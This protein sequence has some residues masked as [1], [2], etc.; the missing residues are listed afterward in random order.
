MDPSGHFRSLVG[1]GIQVAFTIGGEK[2]TFAFG[3]DLIWFNDK[4]EERYGDKK[5]H[6]YY[7]VSFGTAAVTKESII[8]AVAD[9]PKLLLSKCKLKKLRKILI[10]LLGIK[11]TITVQLKGVWN[12]NGKFKSYLD[13]EGSGTYSGFNM[14]HITG[15][16]VTSNSYVCTSAGYSTSKMPAF[17][18][19]VVYSIF[20]AKRTDDLRKVMKKIRKKIEKS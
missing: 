18:F 11:L 10:A 5:F 6:F 16:L 4:V 17:S 14:M 8:N 12:T 9:N 2:A 13:Y 7:S 20:D 3:F 1:K 19:G 15:S